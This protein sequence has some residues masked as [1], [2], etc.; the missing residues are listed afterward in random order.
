[1][2]PGRMAAWFPFSINE[3]EELPTTTQNRGLRH[4]GGMVTR[5]RRDHD[6][7]LRDHDGD[8]SDHDAPIR[9][10]TMGDPSD[11]DE[12]YTHICASRPGATV[13]PLKCT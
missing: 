4:S 5:S 12:R 8:P 11:H 3:P 9:M 7:D 13:R 1:M 2:G 10:I 6:D